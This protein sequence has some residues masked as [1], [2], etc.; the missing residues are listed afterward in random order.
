MLPMIKALRG[1]SHSC[2]CSCP[3]LNYHK[4]PVLSAHYT[5]PQLQ[6]LSDHSVASAIH[7]K[8]NRAEKD[9]KVMNYATNLPH[10]QSTRE[11][12]AGLPIR[13]TT[14]I[15]HGH[16]TSSVCFLQFRNTSRSSHDTL[17]LDGLGL[18]PASTC[19]TSATA[20]VNCCPQR[21]QTSRS[22]LES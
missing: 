20:S 3:H 14:I 9:V 19:S 4:I 12:G 16:G 15:D 1:E 10:R 5:P 8:N 18:Q 22:C 21:G 17:Q 13:P 7:L 2:H 11:A 6:L